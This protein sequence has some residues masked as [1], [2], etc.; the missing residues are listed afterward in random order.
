MGHFK[1]NRKDLFFILKEQLNYSS[2]CSFDRYKE[3]DEKMLDMVVSE[4][5]NVA[6]EVVDPL[7]EIGEQWGARLENGKVLA[8]PEF[9]ETFKHFGRDGWIALSRDLEY[10]G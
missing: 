9:R 6:I 5:I 4:A 3:L 8:P 7:Q 1:V 10:R 2:L